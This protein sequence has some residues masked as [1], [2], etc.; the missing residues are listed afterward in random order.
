MPAVGNAPK[1]LAPVTSETFATGCAPLCQRALRRSSTREFRAIRSQDLRRRWKSDVLAHEPQLVSIK[2]GIN[3]VW[4]GLGEAGGG[5]S[6]EKFR[7]T[8]VEILERLRDAL[9]EVA[10]VLCE[11]TVIWP[12]A[13]AQ[14][15]TALTPYVTAV[16]E[17]GVKFQARAVV[18]AS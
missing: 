6:I 8:Y 2:I 11:P 5:T 12:P 9:P 17:L 18:P 3:D 7:E 10:M 4:H 13:P 15:N 14:G 16:R 1:P